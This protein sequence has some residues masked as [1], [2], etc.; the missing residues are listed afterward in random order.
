MTTTDKIKLLCGAFD[1]DIV[2]LKTIHNDFDGALEIEFENDYGLF[3]VGITTY[4]YFEEWGGDYGVLEIY[5]WEAE[6][7][8]SEGRTTEATDDEKKK[9][10]EI[11]YQNL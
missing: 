6:F 3:V 8:D 7:Y 1:P 9:M 2:D 11:I 5:V 10:A 4:C